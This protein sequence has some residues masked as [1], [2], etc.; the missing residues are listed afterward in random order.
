MAGDGSSWL[1]FDSLRSGYALYLDTNQGQYT[2]TT[3]IELTSTGFEIK[4]TW[5]AINA[6]GTKYIYYAH[7]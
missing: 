2:N 3:W 7:A 1:T 5:G 6:S 4:L